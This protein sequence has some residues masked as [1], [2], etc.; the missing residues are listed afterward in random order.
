VGIKFIRVY[1]ISLVI[2]FGL[3]YLDI[4]PLSKGV[5]DFQIEIISKILSL[6]LDN[7]SSNR[8]VITPHYGLI[9]EKNCNGL[10][11]YFIFLATI[12]ALSNSF[13]ELLFWGVIGYVV[14]GVVNIVRIYIIARLVLINRSNFYLAHDIFG[15]ILLFLTA[16]L[17]LFIF[18]RVNRRKNLEVKN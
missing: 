8:I 18:L 12:V 5:N 1:I 2:L 13:R 14:I 9:I 6:F 4:S 7:I 3:F 16:I 15:N 17:L 10:M 11:V